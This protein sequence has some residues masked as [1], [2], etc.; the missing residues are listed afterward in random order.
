MRSKIFA[1]LSVAILVLLAAQTTASA[2]TFTVNV[3][4]A[5]NNFVPQSLT[6]TRGDTVNWV[7]VAGLHSTTSGACCVANGVWDSGNHSPAFSFPVTFNASGTFSYFCRQHLAAMQGTI[8]VQDPPPAEVPEA[9]TLALM[10]SGGAGFG[11]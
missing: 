2:A 5:G 10:L 8:I 7:W 3:G 4:Q 11:S 6:I 1:A 9:D